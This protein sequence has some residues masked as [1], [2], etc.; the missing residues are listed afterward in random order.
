MVYVSVIHFIIIHSHHK[1][2]YYH[3]QVFDQC[4]VVRVEVELMVPKSID[5]SCGL[6]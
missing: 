4:N 2:I 5:I 3:G 6:V 1:D